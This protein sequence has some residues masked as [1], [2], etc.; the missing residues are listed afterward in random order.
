M[1]FFGIVLKTRNEKSQTLR[2][3][4]QS[5][6]IWPEEKDLYLLSLDILSDRDFGVFFDNLMSQVNKSK[7]MK[8]YSIEPLTSKII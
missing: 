3:V 4:I 1:Q 5:L 2:K 7:N 8:E 6:N